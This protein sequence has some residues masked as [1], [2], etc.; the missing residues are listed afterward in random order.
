MLLGASPARNVFP[1]GACE[2]LCPQRQQLS[3]VFQAVVPRVEIAC[4][5]LRVWDLQADVLHPWL[6]TSTRDFKYFF[7]RLSS[8]PP[9]FGDSSY[10]YIRLL[11]FD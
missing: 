1:L 10:T 7:S 8:L 11:G 2:I 6:A 9:V 4:S 3:R 5:L